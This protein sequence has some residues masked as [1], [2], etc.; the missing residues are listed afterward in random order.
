MNLSYWFA[1]GLLVALGG[2]TRVPFHFLVAALLAALGGAIQL[3][4]KFALRGLGLHRTFLRK[5]P[6]V[7]DSI[8]IRIEV[9]NPRPIAVPW[10]R[11][12]DR[13][14]STRRAYLLSIGPYQSVTFEDSVIASERGAVPT[15]PAVLRTADPLGFRVSRLE[16]SPAG[17]VLVRPERIL[18]M[19]GQRNGQSETVSTDLYGRAGKAPVPVGPVQVFERYLVGNNRVHIV[20]DL[21]GTGIG[22]D[23]GG[24][25]IPGEAIE[26]AIAVAAAA[27]GRAADLGA[28][29]ALDSNGL[30]S[31]R[32]GRLRILER[33]GPDQ[34]RRISGA[35]SRVRPGGRIDLAGLL[36]R[37]VPALRP[38]RP[39][40]EGVGP[41][42]RVAEAPMGPE[43][44]S[45]PSP[46]R[47]PLILVIT[48]GGGVKARRHLRHLLQGG[49]EVLVW[50]IGDASWFPRAVRI[51]AETREMGPRPV[52]HAGSLFDARA[53]SSEGAGANAT[54]PTVDS[55]QD[56]ATARVQG[57]DPDVA[58]QRNLDK[59]DRPPAELEQDRGGRPLQSS[60]K[61]PALVAELDRVVLVST[62]T[63]LRLCWVWPWLKFLSFLSSPQRGTV[64]SLRA[65]TT[66]VIGSWAFG[67]CLR[68]VS[69]KRGTH[70][71]D[72]K[73]SL[74]QSRASTRA[75]K[76]ERWKPGMRMVSAIVAVLACTWFFEFRS[77]VPLRDV[78]WLRIMGE[79][80]LDGGGHTFW[81]VT[82]ILAAIYV[83][84]GTLFDTE[85][86][87]DRDAIW[88]G[89]MITVSFLVAL[90]ALLPI[91]GIPAELAPRQELLLAFTAALA[92]LLRS[93][94]DLGR[95][96]EP[97]AI[98]VDSP[99]RKS[100][101]S[102]G[103]VGS[104]LRG[105]GGK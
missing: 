79:D 28:S 76:L 1:V 101:F 84:M 39:A 21:V 64:V 31:G 73:P 63:I 89:F 56:F 66:L 47:D 48:V 61:P 59:I 97:A 65:L 95:A 3:W 67:Q 35:L 53:R 38:Q 34:R 44:S 68:F 46:L 26:T 70:A 100:L 40:T 43:R 15:G 29:I 52:P 74:G 96:L 17:S 82:G 50:S 6:A 102:W 8:G 5:D 13:V 69:R 51:D 10:V 88:S 7:G 62:R 32:R 11:I 85:E 41:D 42:L 103:L 2:I 14:G 25:A 45:T 54:S 33:T 98:Y 71:A 72:T 23:R 58:R 37:A 12:D 99:A 80:L 75:N 30:A 92:G 60:D 4:G 55:R 18:L 20:L 91:A 16:G 87:V 77:V 83:W 78:A 93:R 27:A 57:F 86:R 105:R 94:L 90:A 19:T 36:R 81:R 9:E 22:T 104:Q 24:A 49:R